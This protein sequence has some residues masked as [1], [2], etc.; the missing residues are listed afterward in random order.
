MGLGKEP[1][2]P[3]PT[4]PPLGCNTQHGVKSLK[5]VPWLLSR[6]APLGAPWAARLGGVT[7]AVPVSDGGEVPTGSLSLPELAML[8]QEERLWLIAVPSLF[9][10]SLLC[11]MQPASGM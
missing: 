6:V 9:L 5:D 4:G 11:R 2:A 10:H 8:W 3:E 1:A 7:R